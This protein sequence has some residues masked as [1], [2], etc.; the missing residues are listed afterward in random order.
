MSEREPSRYKIGQ[1]TLAATAQ[2]IWSNIENHEGRKDFFSSREQLME[3]LG[4]EIDDRLVTN[5]IMEI[6]N[7]ACLEVDGIDQFVLKSDFTFSGLFTARLAFLVM[8][9]RHGKSIAIPKFKRI[10][11]RSFI[12]DMLSREVSGKAKIDENFVRSLDASDRQ[13]FD[14]EFSSVKD[15]IATLNTL[16]NKI[17]AKELADEKSAIT[18]EH[19]DIEPAFVE[20]IMSKRNDDCENICKQILDEEKT[21]IDDYLKNP[22]K[23]EALAEYIIG[24]YMDDLTVLIANA[25]NT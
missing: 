25:R 4:A 6:V 24:D 13:Y 2:F 12:D 7:V 16:L 15:R 20:R 1:K 3:Y 19:P 8:L 14:D 5:D 21:V 10:V 17:I 22:D 18:C 9:A 11:R 23:I